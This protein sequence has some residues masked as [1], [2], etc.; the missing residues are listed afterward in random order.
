MGTKGPADEKAV[1]AASG[2]EADADA[3]ASQSM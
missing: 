3:E 2:A 1:D